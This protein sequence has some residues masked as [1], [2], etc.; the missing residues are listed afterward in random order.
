[1]V[2]RGGE[3]ILGQTSV[4]LSVHQNHLGSPKKCWCLVF[5]PCQPSQFLRVESGIY[6]L[7]APG[8]SDAQRGLKTA[9]VHEGDLQNKGATCVSNCLGAESCRLED[10]G[11]LA[12]ATL[13]FRETY[14]KAM[15][16]ARAVQRARARQPYHCPLR[17]APLPFASYP[18]NLARFCI[19][20]TVIV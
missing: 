13:G 14:T 20:G 8:D 10:S 2:G 16:E 12:S 3:S 6:I 1:M 18:G 9:S 4:N 11:P 7:T 15:T 5:T 19:F 17:T